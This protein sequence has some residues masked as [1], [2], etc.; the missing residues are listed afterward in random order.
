MFA[1][2]EGGLVANLD[3]SVALRMKSCTI[4]EVDTDSGG[5]IVTKAYTD[6]SALTPMSRWL[7][8][9]PHALQ[10]LDD[11]LKGIALHNWISS[12]QLATSERIFECWQ[13]AGKTILSVLMVDSMGK[14]SI[15]AF[16]RKMHRSNFGGWAGEV[17]NE[18]KV[19]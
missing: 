7:A 17:L 11:E 5:F 1:S 12:A 18:L 15:C 2:L 14:K 10:K 9:S 13:V 19:K 4:H 8:K 6:E 16:L 3:E